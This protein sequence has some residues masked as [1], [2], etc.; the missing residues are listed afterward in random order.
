MKSGAAVST[1]GREGRQVC[2]V[3]AAQSSAPPILVVQCLNDTAPRFEG[4]RSAFAGQP[5]VGLRLPVGRTDGLFIDAPLAAHRLPEGLTVESRQLLKESRIGLCRGVSGV[6]EAQE[7]VDSPE[8]V[9]GG[10]GAGPERSGV[11][12]PTF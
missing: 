3:G 2:L 9:R 4:A 8:P 10:G 11:V 5:E 12:S 1:T 6:V 7:L